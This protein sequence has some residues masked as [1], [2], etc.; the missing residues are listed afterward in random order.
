MSVIAYGPRVQFADR[1]FDE[2]LADEL[3]ALGIVRPLVVTDA[4]GRAALAV[5]ADWRE[6][7]RCALPP[8][9]GPAFVDILGD[10]AGAA[11]P[12]RAAAVY[13]G[14][15][16]DG[17]LGI[18][19][20]AALSLA[21][22]AGAVAGDTGLLAALARRG[23]GPA[24][25]RRPRA[26]VALV[27]VTTAGGAGLCPDLRLPAAAPAA[28]RWL[29]G[30]AL[31]PALVVCD[32]TLTEALPA[33]ATAAAG[34]D[35]IAH[36]VESFLGTTFNPPADGIALQGLRLAA[37]A[38]PRAV[39]DGRDSEAR[40]DLMAAAV[41]AGL[42]AQK[43]LGGVHALAHALEDVA[44]EGATP[45]GR[46]HAALLPPFLRFNAPAVGDRFHALGEAMRLAPGADLD[47][48]LADFGAA[49]ALPTRLAPLGLS[50]QACDRVARAAEAEPANRTNPRHATARDYRALIE[51]AM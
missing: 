49:I 2:A 44:A 47:A 33:P 16:C 26:P 10:A 20:A 37:A 35:V 40:R 41:C 34:M 30:A 24:V 8:G 46:L 50:A 12:G 45:H 22:L 1:A 15:G 43:G 17:V 25:P 27:P 51:A 36:C 4:P 48:A 21:R 9:S 19:G 28:P 29:S 7:V 18:G 38:L 3:A 13:A 5:G 11:D 42:A 23:A 6:R 39:A 32:P 14:G 31:V